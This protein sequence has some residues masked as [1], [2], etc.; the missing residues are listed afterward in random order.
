MKKYV[1]LLVSACFSF[2]VANAEIVE[3]SDLEIGENFSPV[4]EL[5]SRGIFSGIDGKAALDQN[6]LKNHATFLLLKVLGD[7]TPTLEEAVDRGVLSKVPTDDKA[8][9]SKA[10][11]IVMVS[12]AFEVPVSS[13]DGKQ[14]YEPA[15]EVGHKIVVLG[16]DDKP[17][18]LVDRGF[19]VRTVYAYEKIFKKKSQEELLV[20]IEK[21]L[22]VVRDRFAEEINKDNYFEVEKQIWDTIRLTGAVTENSSRLSALSDYERVFLIA[23][24]MRKN[25]DPAFNTERLRWAKFFLNSGLNKL[26][27]STDFANDLLIILGE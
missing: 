14:W 4:M 5:A 2:S 15:W 18:D 17:F 25:P 6:I 23:L 22:M 26:P 1:L 11:W 27:Q 9:L 10:E 12:R 7:M 19:A 3:F 21:N 13:A 24:E 20:T 16:E 8:F